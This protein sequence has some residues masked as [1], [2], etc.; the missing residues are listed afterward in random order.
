MIFG[1]TDERP[2]LSPVFVLSLIQ[3][4]PDTSLTHAL[5]SGGRE[6]FGWGV[7]RYLSAN[8]YDA[9]N[10]NTRASGRWGKKGAPEIAP[11]PRPQGVKA[12]KKP[13]SVKDIF[14]RFGQGPG[15]R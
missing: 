7:D 2:G 10:Q 5:A 15:R 9:I 3:R 8:T 14:K 4:L 13:A 12:K 11:Y 1:G 6:H